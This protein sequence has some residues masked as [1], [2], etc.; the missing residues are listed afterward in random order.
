MKKINFNEVIKEIVI[1]TVAVAIICSCS[2]FFPC[3]ESYRPSA[4]FSGLGI[5]LANF[6]AAALVSDYYDFECSTA[7][8][9]FFDMRQ[10]IRCENRLH[11]YYAACFYRYF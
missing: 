6:C 11:Q 8:H 7:D 10:G 3:T 1:L 5:V 2:L 9:R 4:V